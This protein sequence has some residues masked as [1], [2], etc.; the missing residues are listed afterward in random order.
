M[1]KVGLIGCGH[2][3]ETYFRSQDYFNN[4]NIVACAD[5][6][7][8]NAATCA[9]KY[10]VNK[11]TIDELFANKDIDIILNLT[12]PQAHFSTIKKTLVSGK[13][14]YC[15]KPISTNYNEGNE[16]LTLAKKND[17]FLGNAPDTFLGGG[18]QLARKIIDSNLIGEIKLGSINFSF[19]GVQS[20]HPNPDSWFQKGGGPVIDMGPYYFTAL[21][22]LLGPAKN[23]RARPIKVQDF[24]EIE[25]GDRKGEK[26]KVEIPTTII[27][28][29]EF[30]NGAVIELF[31]S[32]DVI[33]HKKNHI[34]LY[35]TKGSIIV[36]DPNM[37][38][39]SVFTSKIEG[40]DWKEHSSSEMKLGKINIFNKSGRSNEAST[41]ANYRGVGLSEMIDAIENNKINRC[42]GELALHVLD[43]IDSTINAAIEGEEKDLRSTCIKPNIFSEEEIKI[44]MKERK[45]SK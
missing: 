16:L 22:N 23:V 45:N 33:N 6:N 37:F 35:G 39:G 42:N 34:E 40:G 36:P 1:L 10:N 13:H 44:L 27:G 20:F 26:I 43:I 18:S 21:V 38:G 4:I 11:M 17:L 28:S 30:I 5:I 24:R 9:R 41:N 8:D 15:E 31:L 19:P 3:S 2:I 29:I 7:E 14:S 25:S 12:T 32:F